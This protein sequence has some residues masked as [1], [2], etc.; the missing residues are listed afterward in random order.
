[1]DIYFDWDGFG[2]PLSLY[3]SSWVRRQ[4]FLFLRAGLYLAWSS[5]ERGLG[6]D[7]Q[8]IRC[9][10]GSTCLTI[11][12]SWSAS[13]SHGLTFLELRAGELIFCLPVPPK[14]RW[15][16]F[17]AMATWQRLSARA[18]WNP[19]C[20]AWESASAAQEKGRICLAQSVSES[21]P[22]LTQAWR[23]RRRN[24]MTVAVWLTAKGG[25]LQQT[26]GLWGSADNRC[27]VAW[28]ILTCQDDCTLAQF[29]HLAISESNN[30]R[31]W[32]WWCR[33]TTLEALYCNPSHFCSP[34]GLFIPTANLGT[35]C[36]N[37][38]SHHG[39]TWLRSAVN[40][41]WQSWSRLGHVTCFDYEDFYP[42]SYLPT[43]GRTGCL[44]NAW[45]DDSGIWKP[46]YN[47]VQ[48]STMNPGF[49]LDISWLWRPPSRSALATKQLG[50]SCGCWDART[51]SKW[52]V[53]HPKLILTAF[54]TAFLNLRLGP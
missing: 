53:V 16:P 52:Q 11:A 48:W 32:T 20:H 8:Y 44:E 41:L 51:R 5:Y 4:L 34:N 42:G 21:P 3:E 6:V 50:S 12:M 2:S 25:S 33:C 35:V 9:T 17:P 7:V 14:G 47:V 18:C 45:N 46:W 54:L 27:I 43:P 49:F 13:R 1:M 24:H 22:S 23:R 40:G 19:W 37:S 31:K 28:C 38:V 26:P 39:E 15:S 29:S 30:I 36:A 10:L